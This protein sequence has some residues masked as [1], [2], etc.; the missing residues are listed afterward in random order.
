M[1]RQETKEITLDI[2]AFFE[3]HAFCQLISVLI[4]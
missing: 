1:P 3:D 2:K 4:V